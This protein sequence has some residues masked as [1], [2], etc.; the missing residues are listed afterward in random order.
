MLDSDNVLI[1]CPDGHELQAAKADMAKKLSCPIC[2]VVFTPADVNAS[3]DAPVGMTTDPHVLDLASGK[4]GQPVTY[5][6]YTT[7]MLAACI[8]ATVCQ[9]GNGVWQQVNPPDY[10]GQLQNPAAAI[11]ALGMVCVVGAIALAA[12]VMQLMWIHRIHADA[13]RA[14]PY[15]GASAGLALGL[16]FIPGFNY[17]WT[18]WLMRRLA[19]F[20]ASADASQEAAETPA[21]RA[22]TINLVFGILLACNC[23]VAG[24]FGTIAVVETMKLASGQAGQAASAELQRQAA[25]AATPPLTW[26]AISAVLNIVGVCVYAWAARKMEKALYPR[27]GALEP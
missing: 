7:W 15:E 2:K 11:G 12:V 20:A 17:I 16:S 6:A 10:D 25:E 21:M 19:T 8:V 13:H 5:P 9:S 23:V 26:I 18:A 14:G 3:P 4:L 22:S 1:R 24:V 27:L